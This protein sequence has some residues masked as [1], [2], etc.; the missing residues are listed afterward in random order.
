[1]SISE[2]LYYAN[3]VFWNSV[4]AHKR[5][6]VCGGILAEVGGLLWKDGLST[7]LTH[8]YDALSSVSH[9]K[10]HAA[11]ILCG[12]LATGIGKV[13]LNSWSQEIDKVRNT[14]PNSPTPKHVS[15]ENSKA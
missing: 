14:P 15:S 4:K 1:M 5:L 10:F 9:Y 3:E 12:S 6:L 2:N 8:L 11:T 7:S 13:V